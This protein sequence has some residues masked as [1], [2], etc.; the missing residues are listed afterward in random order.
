MN[1]RGIQPSMRA[2]Q[3]GAA[4][5]VGLVLLMVLTVLAISGMN[6]ATVELQMA[7][8]F[9]YG[10]SAFQAAEVGIERA[11]QSNT[12]STNTNAPTPATLITGST[13]DY[14]ASQVTFTLPNGMTPVP[15]GGYSMGEGTGFS[16]Y[17][18]DVSS[19]GTSAR[20][21]RAVNTQ[22]FYIVGPNNK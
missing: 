9:Q 3:G 16:A 1:A 18:F 15:E 20:N 22:S 13:S 10:Q 17:H 6:T 7:G 8:N 11:M 12:L 2:H 5:V 21:A 4:L 19:T 14:Y